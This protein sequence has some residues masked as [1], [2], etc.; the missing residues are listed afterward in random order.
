MTDF[1]LVVV[2]LG[3]AFAGYQI[4]EGLRRGLVQLGRDTL[5]EVELSAD[6][7][8]LQAAVALVRREPPS[9]KPPVLVAS[10][11]EEM[12]GLGRKMY[13]ASQQQP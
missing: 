7:D 8:T 2:G 9:A 5:F 1:G 3:I 4:G 12:Q 10:T 13:E 11:D 6:D